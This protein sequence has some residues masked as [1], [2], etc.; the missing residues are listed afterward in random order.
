MRALEKFAKLPFSGSVGKIGSGF[1]KET[2][3]VKR[4]DRQTFKH[5]AGLSS[6]GKKA[7]AITAGA[8]AITAATAYNS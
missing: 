4:M 1:R 8:G 5:S 6:Y 2:P 7:A 3:I